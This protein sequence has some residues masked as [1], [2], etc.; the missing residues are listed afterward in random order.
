MKKL[1]SAS[2]ALMLQVAL[3][4]CL[5]SCG[6]D[7]DSP[8]GG[9]T[10][11][12][13]GVYDTDYKSKIVGMWVTNNY[14]SPNDILVVN[15][16]GTGETYMSYDDRVNISHYT[17]TYTLENSNT[18]VVK[19]T[20]EYGSENERYSINWMS[21]DNQSATLED[22]QGNY[23]TLSRITELP[24]VSPVTM[25]AEAVYSSQ[26]FTST[27]LEAYLYTY[28]DEVPT[29][30]CDASWGSPYFASGEPEMVTY[31]GHSAKRY[32]V[33]VTVEMNRGS[34]RSCTLTFTKQS[35]ET[36][37]ATVTQKA[38][39][40]FTLGGGSRFSYDG[41]YY[42]GWKEDKE[43]GTNCC[44]AYADVND[45]STVNV[46]I[47]VSWF[48]L[49]SRN[50]TNYADGT[51]RVY[52]Y[53]NK[54]SNRYGYDRM[55]TVTFSASDGTKYTYTIVQEGLLGKQS[56][57]G[58]GS[59]SGSSSGSGSGSGSS[60]STTY[61][62]VRAL[63]VIQ[64][65]TSSTVVTT[66]NYTS[67]YVSLYKSEGGSRTYLYTSS[68]S[69]IGSASTNYDSYKGSIYVGTYNLKVTEYGVTKTVYYYFD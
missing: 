50:T 66:T 54:A 29:V 7:D 30:T 23:M 65:S 60:S 15:A 40:S 69:L 6:G 49:N 12:G 20:D 45:N 51:K 17:W 13:G 61:T 25:L 36:C 1:F 59:G 11:S 32:K 27:S 4:V 18:M 14:D 16:D 34:E 48:T 47:S 52:F 37:T 33:Y 35:G 62:S 43:E 58:S 53:F 24:D 41:T 44:Y 2:F 57:S 42:T 55:G 9:D 38:F 46:S 67:S 64:T 68:K 8:S 19:V 5:T 10:T 39:Q 3:C 22:S 26:S 63:K 21:S 56:S 28:D 31:K